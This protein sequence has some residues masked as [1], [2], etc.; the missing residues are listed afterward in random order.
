MCIFEDERS[1]H[2]VAGTAPSSG[3]WQEG[4]FGGQDSLVTVLAYGNSQGLAAVEELGRKEFQK[5]WNRG[6]GKD[7]F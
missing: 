7:M 5:S 3:L 1:L 6:H 4:E 2:A